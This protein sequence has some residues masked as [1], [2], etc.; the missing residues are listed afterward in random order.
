MNPQ[1]H[2]FDDLRDRVLKLE[3]QNRRFKQLGVAA[4]IVAASFAVMGQTPSKK[5]VEANEFVLRDS[6]GSIRA[7]L[8]VRDDVGGMP[9]MVLLDAK[10]YASLE[11]DGALPGL[12]GGSAGVADEQG[13]RVG[14][15]LARELLTLPMTKGFKRP[16]E[17]KI[18]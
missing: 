7:K 1:P 12:T 8:S 9:Q 14:T 18:W 2:G 16:W 17:Q 13:H 3:K 5:T 4:L 15:F 6:N 10:G 11:L